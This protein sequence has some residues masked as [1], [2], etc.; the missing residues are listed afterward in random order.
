MS[1]LQRRLTRAGYPQF[2]SVVYFSLAEIAGAV[3]ACGGSCCLVFGLSD[4]WLFALFAAAV[5]YMIPGS[6]H[7]PARPGFG[8]RRFRTACPMRSI[9]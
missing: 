6:V 7:R 4:G 3:D 5:G 9:C 1:R 2:K 8:R